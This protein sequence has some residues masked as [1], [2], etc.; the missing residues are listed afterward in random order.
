[1]TFRLALE[2]IYTVVR[3]GS[4]NQQNASSIQDKVIDSVSIR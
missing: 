3:T 4:E 2:G 1:M